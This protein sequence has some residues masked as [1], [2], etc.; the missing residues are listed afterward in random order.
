[1]LD[2]KVQP[3]FLPAGSGNARIRNNPL[4]KKGIT[5]RNIMKFGTAEDVKKAINVNRGISIISN[6]VIERELAVGRIK[7]IPKLC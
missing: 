6:C 5:L 3:F 4:R 7:A 2:K 1:M